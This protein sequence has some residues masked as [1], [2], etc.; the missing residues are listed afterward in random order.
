MWRVLSVSDPTNL[1]VPVDETQEIT[2]DAE[3]GLLAIQIPESSATGEE[4]LFGVVDG[5]SAMEVQEAFEANLGV[6]NVQVTGGPGAEEAE[7]FRPF[8]YVVKF[9]GSLAGSEVPRMAVSGVRRGRTQ[10]DGSAGSCGWGV[11]W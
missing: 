3:G 2:G 1:A 5:A 9:M 6:G 11:W 8:S 4:K 10:A 7:G